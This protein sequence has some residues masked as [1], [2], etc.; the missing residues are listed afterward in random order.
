MARRA[1]RRSRRLLLTL[2]AAAVVGVGAYLV[3][4]V[5]LVGS[6]APECAVTAGSGRYLL[7]PDQA[8]NA[9]TIAGVG[10]RLGAP[11]H[12]VTVAIATALQESKLRNVDHGDLDSLG[13]FQQ[14]PSQGW[15][16][17][18]QVS[19]PTYAAAAFYRRLLQ[20]PHWES[21]P[22]ADAA[23]EVQRSAAG[24]AYADWEPQ[25]RAIAMATTGEVT[26]GLSCRYDSPQGKA[27]PAA[28]RAAMAK[29][30]GAARTS[31]LP[32]SLDPW[33]TASWLVANAYGF[34]A[35]AVSFDGWTW[36][37]D[38]GRWRHTG[39]AGG[40]TVHFADVGNV[41]V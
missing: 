38:S 5:V 16:T 14:R 21:L 9:A 29:A 2:A 24:S 41:A 4:H 11:D 22:V 31:A 13:L 40:F 23:Q 34:G 10:K 37:A 36:T 25:A 20:V 39:G 28:L 1:R 33:T 8:A 32:S 7:D 3:A 6:V 30:L 12:A 17:A 18:A 35:D 26:A 15:G 19:D 27:A